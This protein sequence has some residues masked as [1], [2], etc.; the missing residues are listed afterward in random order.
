MTIMFFEH[1][2]PAVEEFMQSE[3]VLNDCHLEADC[4]CFASFRFLK[5]EPSE[6]SGT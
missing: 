3:H 5:D 2:K 4:F 6:T 1:P